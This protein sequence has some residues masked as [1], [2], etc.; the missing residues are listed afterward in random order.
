MKEAVVACCAFFPFCALHR[1]SWLREGICLLVHIEFCVT[2]LHLDTVSVCLAWSSPL[3]RYCCCVECFY[4]DLNIW[5]S[6]ISYLKLETEDQW[7]VKY[8]VYRIIG[9]GATFSQFHDV[10]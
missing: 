4:F 10:F 3:S 2:T 9:S 5:Y 8:G 1:C 7:D 6:T